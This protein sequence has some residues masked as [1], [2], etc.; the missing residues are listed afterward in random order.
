MYSGSTIL[1]SVLWYVHLPCITWMSI[2]LLEIGGRRLFR[3]LDG[4]AG[5]SPMVLDDVGGSFV[6]RIDAI[7]PVL[8][9]VEPN[10]LHAGSLLQDVSQ[11]IEPPPVIQGWCFRPINRKATSFAR[12]GSQDPVL[13]LKASSEN[14]I[15]QCRPAVDW[16]N[17]RG[18]LRVI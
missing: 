4:Q 7:R 8:E 2:N 1:C 5:N 13:R 16:N 17:H 6:T 9:V 18:R 14:V 3:R 10:L 11:A 12:C 15:S